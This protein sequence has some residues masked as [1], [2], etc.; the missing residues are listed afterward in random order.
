NNEQQHRNG[1]P[2][3]VHKNPK[4]L[5]TSFTPISDRVIMVRIK[6]AQR[7]LNIIQVYAPTSNKI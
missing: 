4:H 1:V 2:I 6:T 3:V 5:V 7:T